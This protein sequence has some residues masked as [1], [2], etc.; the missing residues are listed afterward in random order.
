M[1]FQYLS[2][3][4]AS[5]MLAATPL[6]ASNKVDEQAKFESDADRFLDQRAGK[7]G[8]KLT[9]FGSKSLQSVMDTHQLE[10]R[11]LNAQLKSLQEKRS[12]NM[13]A[14][15]H[16]VA[17]HLTEDKLQLNRSQMLLVE[18]KVERLKSLKTLYTHRS[19]INTIKTLCTT[20]ADDVSSWGS[21]ETVFILEN[22]GTSKSYV[23]GACGQYYRTVYDQVPMIVLLTKKAPVKYSAQKLQLPCIGFC[24]E[25][26]HP[27]LRKQGSSIIWFRDEPLDIVIPEAN[28]HDMAVERMFDKFYS[29]CPQARENVD[30]L[31][32]E[33][34]EFT[35]ALF[36]RHDEL[37]VKV[38]KLK[39]QRKKLLERLTKLTSGL[40]GTDSQVV[41]TK[42]GDDLLGLIQRGGEMFKLVPVE[43]Q[44]Q[45]KAIAQIQHETAAALKELEVKLEDKVA[46]QT[47]LGGFVDFLQDTYQLLRRAGRVS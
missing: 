33:I 44:D 16:A 36:M 32:S 9:S 31:N 47:I 25:D 46:E 40:I 17:V 13:S 11:V 43:D 27:F 24:K 42:K 35:E 37:V 3:I 39:A 20:T 14:E 5:S 29:I 26:E 8:A 30:E 7:V 2:L 18:E 23:E 4:F 12:E 19:L 15:D 38:K 21:S 1:K 10:A 28:A 41:L 22:G 45:Q 6:I 34:E